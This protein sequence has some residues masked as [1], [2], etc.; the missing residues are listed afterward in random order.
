[1]KRALILATAMSAGAAAGGGAIAANAAEVSLKAASFLPGRA[2]YAK[3]FIRWTN[4]V[5]KRCAGHVKISVIG[6]AAIK[7]L[8][9]WRA[10]KDGVVDMHYGP[11]NYYKGVMPAAD[12]TILA[13]NTPADQRK[14][15][16]WA[17]MN[18]LYNEKLN[19]QYLTSI[20]DGVNFFIYTNKPAKNGRFDG[21]R[22]RSVPI[23]DIFFRS[24]GAKP[25]R[26][27]P[28]SV[29][30]AL[31][32][33]A[34]D[35]YGWPLWGVSDF[36]WHKHTKYRYG[37]GFFSAAV[38][39]LVNLDTWNKKLSAE[40]RDC[41]MKMT[42][43]LEGQWP[44]WRAAE[45]ASQVETQ[46]KVGIKYVDLGA[47]FRKRAHDLHWAALEKA[48]PTFIKAIRPLLLTKGK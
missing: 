2:V 32:R 44:S 4:E 22:L 48:N 10:L 29:Y 30:T 12:V 14:N 26:M 34:I 47:D 16:A 37:P 28:P 38:N 11:A 1:M 33:K 42:V 46:K 19:A 35:G 21:M 3:N 31:E 5:N 20:L 36:G 7:S 39:I 15:G 45:N 17:M 13:D 25:V 18:K 24:L 23:Y 8:E 41:L 43:W 40:G 6:P 9:Q 27:G